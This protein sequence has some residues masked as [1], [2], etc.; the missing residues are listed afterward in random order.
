MVFENKVFA[1]TG[2]GNGIGR[3]VVLQLLQKGAKVVALDI[4]EKGLQETQELA[5]Q[6]EQN[7]LCHKINI[8]SREEVEALPELINQ[9]FGQIDGVLNVAGIVQPFIKVNDLSYEQIERVMNVNFYGSLYMIKAFLPILLANKDT[10][11]IVNVSSMGGFL[12]VPGQS[13]YGASKAALKLLTEGLYAECQG[14]NVRVCGVFPGAVATNI[15]QNSNVTMES[16]GETKARTMVTAEDAAKQ[17]LD[18]IEKEKFRVMI[19][20]DSKIM[21]FLYR[22]NPKRAVGMITK[23]MKD[24]LK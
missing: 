20:K 18:G 7:L 4:S 24:L 17:I 6:N 19:G 16:N 22:L 15:L 1:V 23:Q 2:G 21:D 10:S 3:H 8:A 12:P 13:V 14:T 9:K 11:V 5:K